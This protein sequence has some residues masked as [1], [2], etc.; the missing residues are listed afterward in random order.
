MKKQRYDTS[1]ITDYRE[2][3]EGYLTV[4]VPIT[5]PGVFAYQRSDGTV[6][7]EAKLPEDLFSDATI[8]SARS[9][10]VT[11]DHPH[12][13]VTVE[14]YSRYSKGLSHTDSRV[15]DFKLYV[16]MTI[17]DK[18]LI[19][20]I[21]DGKKEISIGF[22]S[23][24]VAEPGVY[25]GQNYEFVQ[26]NIEI[27]HIAIVD[28][29]RAGP[30]V[31]IRGDSDAWQIDNQTKGGGD[32]PKYTIDGKEYEVDS[33]V[34][35]YLDAQQARLDAANTKVKDFDSLQ[36]RYDATEAKLKKA[37]ADLEEAKKQNLS[38][39]ELDKKVQARVELVS[40]ASNYL[41]DSFDFTGKTDRE[42]KEAV[43][44]KANPDFKGDGKSDEYIDAFFDATV[45]RVKADGFSS[46]GGNSLLTGDGKQTT[47]VEAKRQARLNIK[48]QKQ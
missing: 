27:N 35:A 25:R 4:T 42:I 8:Y 14:N 1:F 20:K 23:D 17:T 40:N 18:N 15:E 33:T 16:S 11:D 9:K 24:V 38:A 30:E 32:M 22:L 34:K 44:Q 12:E 21:H 10:P 3:P 39:D 19:Q 28:Q 47:G 37:E 13:P 46:T 45:D 7:M 43:I 36:G 5:R 31:S 26:R 29:G 41:G 6:Q 2:T 48:N